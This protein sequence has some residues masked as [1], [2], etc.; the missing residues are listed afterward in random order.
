M[1]PPI[2]GCQCSPIAAVFCTC[3]LLGVG[4]RLGRRNGD[5]PWVLLS[6]WTAC[7]RLLAVMSLL[8]QDGD[9]GKL[10]TN[11]TPSLMCMDVLQACLCDQ[12][13]GSCTQVCL[14]GPLR[15]VEEVERVALSGF[16]RNVGLLKSN[17]GHN[18]RGTTTTET[19]AASL[20]ATALCTG[21]FLT[22]CCTCHQPTSGLLCLLLTLSC[23]EHTVIAHW[24]HI[25]PRLVAA[26]PA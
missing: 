24:A 22:A 10:H 20:S 9:V 5:I 15:A 2:L 6:A 11:T 13:W 8:L 25:G 17:V 12:W 1:L 7:W 14:N 21:W 3:G 26:A 4:D 16:D 19:V 23:A 18:T